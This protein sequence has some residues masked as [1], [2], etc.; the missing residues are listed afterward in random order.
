MNGL[1]SSGW[2]WCA[3]RTLPGLVLLLGMSVNTDAGLFGFGGTNWKEEVQLSDGKVIVV[4]RKMA[5]EG[6]GDEWAF[7]R[8][9]S[10]PKTYYIR[11]EHPN[12]SGKMI[13]WYST[14][15]SPQTWPEVPLIF[16]IVAVSRLSSHW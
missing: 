4:E 1:G 9:G 8:S 12:G 5:S 14:K 6:G 3:W 15:I 16:D 10:K 13:E 7:N 11:F 2:R